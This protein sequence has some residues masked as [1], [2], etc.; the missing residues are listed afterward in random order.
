MGWARK[1]SQSVRQITG[2]SNLFTPLMASSTVQ[3]SVRAG[4]G[5]F[6]WLLAWHETLDGARSYDA[7][8]L[9]SIFP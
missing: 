7:W 2:S 5:A 9:V 4:G 1:V 6:V 3:P 8:T